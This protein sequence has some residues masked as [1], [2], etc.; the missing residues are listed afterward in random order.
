[1]V[2]KPAETY[3]QA[4]RRQEGSSSE[5]RRKGGET[6]Y[7]EWYLEEENLE[8]G[9]ISDE[10]IG[11]V[12]VVIGVGRNSTLG[13]HRMRTKQVVEIWEAPKQRRSQY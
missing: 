7:P 10:Q 11:K 12:A 3:H 5:D 6:G 1:M 8:L 13:K 2:G 4:S 9:E